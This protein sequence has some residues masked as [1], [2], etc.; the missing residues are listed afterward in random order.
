MTITILAEPEK[1]E[2]RRRLED[3]FW[4]PENQKNGCEEIF[5]CEYE[6]KQ[7][8]KQHLKNLEDR[9]RRYRTLERD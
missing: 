2:Q 8:E 7:I 5:C 6:K 4:L 9:L 3:S 1:K